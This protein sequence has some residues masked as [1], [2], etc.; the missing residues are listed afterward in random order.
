LSLKALCFAV[1]LAF[2]F[3]ALSKE[4]LAG[5][6][7]IGFSSFR[8]D[9]WDIWLLSPNKPPQRLTDHP[10]LDYDPA[11]SPDGRY[12]V[13]T[14]ERSG[15]PNLFVID[16]LKK[17][18]ERPLVTGHGMKDQAALTPD[19]HTLIFVS[20]RDGKADLY[21]L[22]FHPT[23]TT[24]VGLARRLTGGNGANLRPTFS[25]DGRRIIFTSTRDA[26]EH[27]DKRFPFAIQTSGNLYAMELAS[28]EV[29]RLT[30][31]DGWDGSAIYSPDGKLI[32][33]YSDRTETHEPRLFSMKPDGSDQRPIGP[34]QRA[35][36]PALLPD[37]RI[38]LE[39][40]DVGDDGKPTNWRLRALSGDSLSEIAM[41]ADELY[42]HRPVPQPMG[43]GILCHGLSR[44][45]YDAGNH[46]QGFPGP[47]I[48]SGY[49][50][51]RLLDGRPVAPYA[52]RNAF[53]APPNPVADE[54]A[55]RTS[56][57][58]ADAIST[59][60]AALR[61]LLNLDGE[62]LHADGRAIMGMVWLPDGQYLAFAVKRFRSTAARGAIWRVRAD[63][64]GAT[65]ITGADVIAAGMPDFG[66]GGKK[67]VFAAKVGNVT[68]IMMMNADGSG[69]QN[70]THSSEREN[71]PALSPDGDML[72]FG[73]D[74]EGLLDAST[75][76]RRMALYIARLTAEG[77]LRGVRR[78]TDPNTQSGHPRF[79]PDGRWLV[80]TSG[81]NGINDEQPLLSSL[82]FSPQPYGEIWAYRISD[83]V[84]VR[85][86]DDK[87]EDGA[88]F[89]APALNRASRN[90]K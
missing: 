6:E 57:S 62:S 34:S 22:P 24:D 54:F 69:I 35:I 9:G 73:S 72:A 33:F 18:P 48:A 46:A 28:G 59:D 5:L 81:V 66:A 39:T 12:I 84:H 67:I 32:Y 47:A 88:P 82:V 38:A 50:Q 53:D 51:R 42:C 61:P 26:I 27:G 14:S 17:A 49:P 44:A 8:P 20:T 23:R 52:I 40:W 43:Q 63:G 10:A 74:R 75:G 77:S 25:P 4:P 55:F 21:T 68:N 79:S 36:S 70:L 90:S 45:S 76:E 83:G 41:A 15:V 80:Y 37:G 56:A 60:G 87:W 29:V 7:R 65:A 89:W 19:G 13:F 86:T 16:T 71:F 78:I 30:H 31:T 2:S 64:S 85:L 3:N 11:W 1:S 58:T